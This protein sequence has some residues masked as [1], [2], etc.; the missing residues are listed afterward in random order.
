MR[1]SKCFPASLLALS[2]A[3]I[4]SNAGAQAANP[5]ADVERIL[6]SPA[7][8]A[9]V[10]TIDKEHGRIVED[11]IR[12]TEI[13]APPFKEEAR[14][15]EYEKMFKAVGLG[16]VEGGGP[17]A[18]FEGEG[19]PLGEGEAGEAGGVGEGYDWDGRMGVICRVG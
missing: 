4:G 10:A 11:G 7:F 1:N 3:L 15:R 2:L 18:Q 16:E 17:G 13:P 12:L 9:A 19:G 14:A 5:V 8:K 6:A